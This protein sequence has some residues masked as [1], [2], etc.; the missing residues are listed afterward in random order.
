MT[1]TIDRELEV[2][3]QP[4]AT[5]GPSVPSGGVP[6][7][8]D[9]VTEIYDPG[10]LLRPLGITALTVAA[11]AMMVGGI[12]G[13]WPARAVAI[14]GGL[15]GVF[16][17]WFC[18]RSP[19][20]VALKQP[21]IVFV[22]FG[23]GVASLVTTEDGPARAFSLMGDAIRSGRLLRPPVPFDPGWRPILMVLFALL[24]F[25]GGW[26]ATAF[27][28]PQLAL[29]LP[30]PVLGLA[31]ISQ[32]AE[33]EFV[34]GFLGFVPV[35]LALGL[36]FGGEGRSGPGL[37][38]AFEFKRA[39]KSLPLLAGGVALLV[40]VGQTN[41]LFPEPTF[42]PS[43]KPQKP[44]SIPIGE[45]K[46]HVLFEIDGDITGP[47]KFGQL[48]VYD[49]KNW[50]LLPFDPE[51]G[52]KIPSSGVVDGGRPGDKTVT[53]TIRDV[54][55]SSVL[56]GVVG[57]TSLAAPD[58]RAVY[59]PRTGLFRLPVGRVKPDTR[60]SMSLPTYPTADQ[61]RLAPPLASKLDKDFTYVPKP[62]PAVRDLIAQAPANLW[63]RLDFARRSLT[64]VVVASG[65]G[66]PSKPVTPAKV[67]DLLVGSHEGTPFEIVA[68]EAMLA[69]WMGV[70]SR[71]G[72]GFD[73]VNDE[74]GVKTVRP[75]NG[76]NWL[77]VYF[78]GYGW[79]PLIGAPPKAKSTLDSNKNQKFDPTVQPSED[80]GV[81]LFIPVEIDDLT[82]LYQRLRTLLFQASPFLA[83]ALALYLALPSVRRAQ[84]RRKRRR[85]AQNEGFGAEIAV[86]YAEFRDL[87]FDL[88]VGDKYA[89]PLEYLGR[90]VD[91]DQHS[92]L[93][94]LVTRATYGDLIND[95][96]DDDVEAA[97]D[98]A[99]SLRRRMFRAQPFQSRALAV[100]SRASLR[101]PYTL[102][103]PNVRILRLRLP[104]PRMRVRSVR[105]LIPIGRT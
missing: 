9:A 22:A 54:G 65:A 41:F 82:Q 56:P 39:L 83:A 15:L 104:R 3:Q 63:D 18:V 20:R 78:E 19:R 31:A 89:T 73:G 32:P 40:V 93:A 14:V 1:A 94:W 95:L 2:L 50:R 97:R 100:M 99:A 37:G 92:E 52:Q 48:D 80:V 24:G 79:V 45:V 102:E 51:R 47:W 67:D 68:A 85:W 30:L 11:A 44:R 12:F 86:E 61:F 46:D 43:Q 27:R 28:R 77:E 38:S 66:D 53:F 101:E 103:V 13:S 17:A 26:V 72:L 33:G 59:D 74:G 21:L 87:A 96:T 64:D 55:T 91:D 4:E 25:A 105:R 69:R 5:G 58:V 71:I 42:K 8:P 29:V 90:V 70:P 81:Q 23:A 60:Y 62:G 98:M 76:A 75:K 84:R 88:N 10:P 6:E 16:W 7:L 57:A 35:L 34:A 36:L 49:G